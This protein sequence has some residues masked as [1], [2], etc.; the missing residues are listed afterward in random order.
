[1]EHV[2]NLKEDQRKMKQQY[3]S[4]HILNNIKT[5][6]NIENTRNK[7]VCM[8]VYSYTHILTILVYI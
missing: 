6:K 4:K 2:L 3:N 1:M 5:S 8:Y 7:Y